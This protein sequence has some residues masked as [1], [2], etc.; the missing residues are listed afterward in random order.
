MYYWKTE[1]PIT[2]YKKGSTALR[3]S[4]ANFSLGTAGAIF[5]T[6]ANLQN[7][8][9]DLVRATRRGENAFCK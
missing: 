5:N 9:E 2:T 7:D 4:I 6:R 8:F 1:K 3:A